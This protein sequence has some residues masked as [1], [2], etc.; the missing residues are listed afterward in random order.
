MK[1]VVDVLDSSS[2]IVLMGSENVKLHLNC[3]GADGYGVEKKKNVFVFVLFCCINNSDSAD[4]KS[5][6][7]PQ[8]CAR[9][10]KALHLRVEDVHFVATSLGFA[11]VASSNTMQ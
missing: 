4:K 6:L 8:S 11:G 3:T 10:D 7:P 9:R 2:L 1:V 5:K